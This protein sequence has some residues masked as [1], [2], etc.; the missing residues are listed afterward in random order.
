MYLDRMMSQVRREIVRTM[1][2]FHNPPRIGL[3]SSYDSQR[4]AVQIQFQPEGTPSGWIPL[5]GL[6]VGNG[7]GIASA[8][9]I[10]DP[11]EVHYQ[12]SDHLV[13][14]VIT[15]HWSSQNKPPQL[16]PGEH[17]FI[18]QSGSTIY[19]KQDGTLVIAG[20]GY[21]QTGQNT[22]QSGN[23]TTTSPNS[24]TDGAQQ[25]PQQQQPQG[26]QVVTLAP[27]GTLTLETPN[28]DRTDQTPNN[29]HWIITQPG[30]TQC[31]SK[32]GVQAL[33]VQ[34]IDGSAALTLLA[35]SAG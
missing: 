35:E 33:P 20:A 28:N 31:V 17:V 34:L 24:A 12:E 30:M 8:P 18:H 7:Y 13:A 29:N 27:D 5:T 6:A 22:Y 21:T 1:R 2:K 10:G 4:H 25:S 19:H 11:V 3:V 9:N 15:R 14:R 16:Q 23:T 26:G 32:K